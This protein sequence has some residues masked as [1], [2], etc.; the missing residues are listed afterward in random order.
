[1]V[2]PPPPP[3]GGKRVGVRSS[4]DEKAKLLRIHY[5]VRL[6]VRKLKTH[7]QL[8]VGARFFFCFFFFVG[9]RLDRA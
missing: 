3:G 8:I 7:P 4:Y 2:V 9:A 5:L 6:D 1:M